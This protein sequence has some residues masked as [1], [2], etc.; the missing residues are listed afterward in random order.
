MLSSKMAF[1]VTN[2]VVN[3]LPKVLSTVAGLTTKALD[4]CVVVVPR[5]DGK[6]QL[7]QGLSV[8]RVTSDFPL[9]N[10]EAAFEDM[11]ILPMQPYRDVKFHLLLVGVPICCLV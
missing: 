9:T 2:F 3:L 4:E 8:P 10:L 1:L 5:T 7:I 11:M 6:K